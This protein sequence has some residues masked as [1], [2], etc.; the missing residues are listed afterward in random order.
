MHILVIALQVFQLILAFICG[1][2]SCEWGNAVYFYAGIVTLLA[3]IVIPFFQSS[4]SPAKRMG[5]AC[6]FLL[7]G[8]AVW[9]IGFIAGD[10]RIMCRLF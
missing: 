10:F 7:S 4:C 1:P 9:V 2:H 8:T 3:L 6:L 5:F